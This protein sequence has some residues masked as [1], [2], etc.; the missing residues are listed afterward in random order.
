MVVMTAIIPRPSIADN[1]FGAVVSVRRSVPKWFAEAS[2]QN[3]LI[4]EGR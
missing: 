2:H 1:E 4:K 3:R